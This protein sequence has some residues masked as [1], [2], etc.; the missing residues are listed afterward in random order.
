MFYRAEISVSRNDLTG[1][2][3]Q[4]RIWLDGRRFN[5]QIFRCQTEGTTVRI[6]ADFSLEIEAVEFA[7]SFGGRVI[8]IG[9]D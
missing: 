9:T 4:M 3:A 7:E 1:R 8:E 6:Q 5:L 2:M